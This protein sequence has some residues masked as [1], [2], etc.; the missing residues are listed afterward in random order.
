MP[1]KEKAVKVLWVKPT[2]HRKVQKVKADKALTSVDDAV[3]YLL[4]L[5]NN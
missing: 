4:K 3:K 1:D 2:T 5:L